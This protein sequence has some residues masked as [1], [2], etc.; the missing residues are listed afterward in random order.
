MFEVICCKMQEVNSSLATPLTNL[1]KKNVKFTW[2]EV[3]EESFRELKSRLVSAPILTIPSGRGGF[4][5]YNNASKKGLGC[6]LMQHGKVIAYAS[7]QLKRQ[8]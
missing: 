8:E 6:V 1:T 5:I 7:R 4:V 2:D 3:C